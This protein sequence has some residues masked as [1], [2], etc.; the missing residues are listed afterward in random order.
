MKLFKQPQLSKR[1]KNFNKIGQLHGMIIM[2]LLGAG[3]IATLGG[4]AAGSIL[5][6]A[7]TLAIIASFVFGH[8][9]SDEFQKAI[10]LKAAAISFALM[11]VILSVTSMLEAY[12]NFTDYPVTTLFYAGFLLH[13]LILPHLGKKANE[14]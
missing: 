1:E 4:Y 6:V 3:F 5:T 13:L 11:M 10:Q 8:R 14:K 2:I 9:R 12:G 7:G